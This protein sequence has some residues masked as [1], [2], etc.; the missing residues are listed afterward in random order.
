MYAGSAYIFERNVSGVWNEVQKIVASDRYRNDLFGFSVS[1]LG[2]LVIV[3]APQETHDATGG[4]N[5][6]FSGSSYIFERNSSGIWNEVQ[7]IVAS[8][9]ASYDNFGQSVA[10]SG[11]YAFVA[12]DQ[13][14]E[15]ASGGN[16]MNQAGSVY[17][18]KATCPLAGVANNTI[19][20]KD[21]VYI[22]G[23]AYHLS[24]IHI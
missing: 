19:C 8:D 24:L 18:F 9:R 21:T 17:I 4:N 1:I 22:N 2:N 14:D 12:A 13:E 23:T 10:I 6:P 7:K 3:G 20:F 15:D 11:N 16:T 5:M